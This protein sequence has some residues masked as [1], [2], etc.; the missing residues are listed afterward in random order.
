MS[1]YQE[2]TT[3][4]AAQYAA[5][6]RERL[7]RLGAPPAFNIFTPR[8]APTYIPI[9]PNPE[10]QPAPRP[11]YFQDRQYE[12]SWMIAV[13]GTADVLETNLSVRMIQDAVCDRF[14]VTY[15][16]LISQRRTAP[17]VLPRHIS[18]HLCRRFTT[19]SH[20]Q[21]GNL[22]GGRDHTVSMFAYRK[23][24]ALLETDP[25]I[26]EHVNALREALHV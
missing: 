4:T 18:M 23:I 19:R 7:K 11:L 6:R 21:I 15:C 16:D 2:Q 24:A 17:I 25:T 3:K 5:E 14:G 20:P 13:C 10:P 9:V 12:R 8:P 1:L 26:A 22:H